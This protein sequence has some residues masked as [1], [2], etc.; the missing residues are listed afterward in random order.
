MLAN[1][2]AEADVRGLIRQAC[3]QHGGPLIT[4]RCGL[5]LG[6]GSG[7]GLGLDPN[8][9]PNPNPDTDP[10]PYPSPDPNTYQGGMVCQRARTGPAGGDGC[11]CADG[12]P[13][14]DGC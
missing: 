3:G 7:L 9:S 8:P 13:Y 2:P 11:L 4:A 10:N 6:L 12:G 1:D 14:G 5:G